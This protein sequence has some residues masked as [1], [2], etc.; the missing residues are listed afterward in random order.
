ML[1]LYHIVRCT[2]QDLWLPEFEKVGDGYWKQWLRVGLVEFGR[3]FPTPDVAVSF[4]EVREWLGDT[5]GITPPKYFD[6]VLGHAAISLKTAF[7]NNQN[8]HF[9]AK[10]GRLCRAFARANL[11]E[12]AQFGNQQTKGIGYKL[13]EALRKDEVVAD[14]WPSSFISFSANV[15]RILKLGKG[16][17]LYEDM[18]IDTGAR[19][20]L[21]WWMQQRFAEM[22]QRKL[23]LSPVMSVS[24]MH[25]RLD[26]TT[27]YL[28]SWQAFA[29]PP[30][31]VIEERPTKTSHPDPDQL[32]AAE[33][34]WKATRKKPNKK[35]HPDLSERQA[36]L[37]AY[38]EREAT[39]KLSEIEIIAY[40]KEV[41]EYKLKY[42]TYV[43]QETPVNP[44]TRLNR[45]LP[46]LKIPKRPDDLTDDEEWGNIRS[47]AIAA[48]D[49]RLVERREA[50]ESQAYKDDTVNYKMYEN[51]IH[52]QAMR[53][54]KPFDDK[55]KKNGWLPSASVCTDGVSLSVT[56]ERIEKVPFMSEADATAARK[57]SSAA[58]ASRKKERAE[59]APAPSEE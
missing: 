47:A 29:P 3:E 13:F 55:N 11:H 1:L 44:V 26:A 51:R 23:M 17:V 59:L 4:E 57:A 32:K 39:R 20:A 24:R 48:R 8:V 22:G 33:E 58:A 34:E 27:L 12:L 6:R 42:P 35:T 49:T 41:A 50:K 46:T 10:L 52:E 5:I 7:L 36:A 14:A 18:K 31:P 54:F 19:M 45:E 30:L 37:H 15:R 43:G 56:Y 25:V 40:R 9:F 16:V 28:L 38:E 2:E 53:L 21:H